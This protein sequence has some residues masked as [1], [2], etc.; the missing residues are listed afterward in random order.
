MVSHEGRET[1]AICKKDGVGVQCNIMFNLRGGQCNL[2]SL[3]SV[4]KVRK[5][6]Y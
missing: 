5:C 6:D 3:H 4:C 2:S 1:S